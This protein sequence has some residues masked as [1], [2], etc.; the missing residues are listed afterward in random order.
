M[1]LCVCRAQVPELIALAVPCLRE[2]TAPV[3]AGAAAALLLPAYAPLLADRSLSADAVALVAHHASD[4]AL[5]AAHPAGKEATAPLEP[6]PERRSPV[7]PP[8]PGVAEAGREGRPVI[9]AGGGGGGDRPLPAGP[10]SQGAVRDVHAAGVVARRAFAFHA[11]GSTTMSGSELVASAQEAY[12]AL[13]RSFPGTEMPEP[14]ASDVRAAALHYSGGS[15]AMDLGQ[16]ERF[17][18]AMYEALVRERA[19]H[20]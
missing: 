19:A 7:S 14:S 17:V 9:A 16:F 5:R 20:R 10:V 13:R 1:C 12:A 8:P 4:A 3:D 11:Q 6:Y 18:C 2:L 15:E